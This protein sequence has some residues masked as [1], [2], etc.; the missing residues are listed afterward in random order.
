MKEAEEDRESTA[1]L[2][3][4]LDEVVRRSRG[5]SRCRLALFAGLLLGLFAM[6]ES[7]AVGAAVSTV[8]ALL[9][10]LFLRRHWNVLD[11]ERELRLL[12]VLRRDAHARRND[13]RRQRPLP[14]RDRA[15]SDPALE[16]G[17]R[18]HAPEPES[19]PLEPAEIEDLSVLEGPRS[20]F[21]VLDVSSSIF[22]ARR[23]RHVLTHPLA[24]QEDILRRQDA[25]RE[26][27]S[28]EGAPDAFLVLL[29]PLAEVDTSRAASALGGPT[30]FAERLGFARVVRVLG[31]LPLLLA[32]A[33]IWWPG[34][35]SLL[36]FSLLAN[37][38]LVLRHAAASNAARDR[39]LSFL[40]LIEALLRLDGAYGRL[41][42]RSDDL[43]SVAATL[44]EAGRALRGLRR[45][46]GRLQLHTLGIVG[47][48]VNVLTLWELRI[49]PVA[50]RLLA[51]HRASLRRSLG[52]LGETEALLSL[53]CPLIEQ[54]GCI[55][56]EPIDPCEGDGAPLIE[57]RDMIHP[58]LDAATA[59]G[60]SI[61]LGPGANVIIV[62][63]SNMSGKSTCLK[64]LALNVLLAGA[65]GA[66]FASRLRWTPLRLFTDINVRDS[67]DD[68]KSYFQ[69]EVERVKGTIEWAA[70]TPLALAIFDELFRGTNS[71]ERLAIAR[72]ILRH[73]R[74]RGI[75]LLV[76]THDVALTRLVTEDREPGMAN[77]HLRER[78]VGSRMTFDYVLHDGPAVSRNAI[79]VLEATGYPEEITAT[80]HAEAGESS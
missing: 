31:S 15:P 57:S 10:A 12:L 20:L 23:L 8:S 17:A 36:V 53:A 48:I 25:V 58:L 24:R 11:R 1:E 54:D 70:R 42:P 45:R 44:S 67:L 66:V 32:A 41:G 61:S 30:P 38:V 47:E 52:A 35:G 60:N 55:L 7:V 43:R 14:P 29:A 49:L 72:S 16:S 13:R 73:L 22:G 69:V 34:A 2:E 80:A 9:F 59:V 19:F 65:G 21:G 26:L 63:G 3:V 46:L 4:E 37:A 79:R 18:L 5:L 76:A 27:A 39:L 68:G 74:S 6:A 50:E 78:V 71:E 62:T 51:E 56:P 75:L 28:A 64:A 77:R 40:P 33:A